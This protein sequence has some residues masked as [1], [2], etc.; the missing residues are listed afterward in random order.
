MAQESCD[1]EQEAAEQARADFSHADNQLIL[2]DLVI[3]G[4]AWSFAGVSGVVVANILAG[5]AVPPVRVATWLITLAVGVG[6]VGQRD[7]DGKNRNRLE[8][9]YQ[10]AKA[11]FEECMSNALPPDA[12]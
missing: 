7:E 3:A 5:T 2:D 1:A 6:A 10:K 9:K 11:K 8:S 12:G 4:A